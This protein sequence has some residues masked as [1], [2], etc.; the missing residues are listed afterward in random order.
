MGVGEIFTQIAQGLTSFIPALGKG[1]I[2]LFSYLFLNFTET[3]AG[4]VT[5]SGFSVLGSL[6]I[7][8][9]VL[10]LVWKIFPK[11]WG[12]VSGLASSR[13]KKKAVK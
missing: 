6:M 4:V 12:F 9:I 5:F 7:A 10:G 13:R 3:E 2:Q 1:V 8:G 11:V